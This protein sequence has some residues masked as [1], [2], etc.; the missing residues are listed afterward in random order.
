M[1]SAQWSEYGGPEAR[2]DRFLLAHGA[3]LFAAIQA[4]DTAR[5][6]SHIAVV[7]IR[8]TMETAGTPAAI[9]PKRIACDF[10]FN[11]RP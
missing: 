4:P 3:H 1:S 8:R 9:Y 5:A 10:A 11:D 6:V 2:V 7:I